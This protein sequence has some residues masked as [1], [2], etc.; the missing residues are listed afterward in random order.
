M[1][2]NLC[3]RRDTQAETSDRQGY[4]YSSESNNMVEIR[5]PAIRGPAMR[6]AGGYCVL[7]ATG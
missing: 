6:R 1:G 4:G 5:G 3:A 2:D 7:R